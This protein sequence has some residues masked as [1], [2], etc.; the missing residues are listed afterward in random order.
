[1]ELSELAVRVVAQHCVDIVYAIDNAKGGKET[2]DE[3]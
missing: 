2:L 3:V 1:M